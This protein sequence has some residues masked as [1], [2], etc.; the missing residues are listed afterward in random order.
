M[1]SPS[2]THTAKVEENLTYNQV[3]GYSHAMVIDK[4]NVLLMIKVK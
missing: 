2:L 1:S 4:A 3:G